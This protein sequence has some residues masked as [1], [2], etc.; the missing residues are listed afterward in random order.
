MKPFLLLS[1]RPEDAAAAG[2]HEAV[3]RFSG[4][5]PAD[6]H[7]FRVE[8]APLPPL[9]LSRYS[10]VL[11]GGGPFNSSDTDKSALQLRVEADLRRVLTEVLEGDLPFLGLCYGVGT[12]TTQLG[13][14]VD[15]THGEPVGAVEI[16]LTDAGREDPLLA[17]LA[18]LPG[19]FRAFVGHKEAVSRLPHGAVLLAT[20]EACPVQMFRVG[21]N[22]YVTQ[23]HPEL[24]G[25]GIGVRIQVY[26]NSGYF[27]PE[28][29]DALLAVTSAATTT[30]QVHGILRR[31]V[32]RYAR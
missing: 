16:Q 27:R 28:E 15:R 19:G 2:E 18:G 29:T 31:F 9:D 21:A 7:Q 3:A 14:V 6:L 26:R 20:S 11:L 1:T 30:P 32:E 10:G 5:A 23:F 17:E 8:E 12:V 4:L 24:D 25:P 13:G 22:C